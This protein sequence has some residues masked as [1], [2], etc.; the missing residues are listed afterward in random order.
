MAAATT[1][2]THPVFG[3]VLLGRMDA[4]DA[5]YRTPGLYINTLPIRVDATQSLVAGLGAVQVQLGE[6]LAHEHAPL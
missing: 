5:S 4:G 3:T 1:G 2:Q 6:L